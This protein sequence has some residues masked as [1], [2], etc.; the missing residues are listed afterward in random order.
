[1]TREIKIKFISKFPSSRVFDT[2]SFVLGGRHHLKLR[3][4]LFSFVGSKPLIQ[5]SVLNADYSFSF[6]R[7][8]YPKNTVTEKR[9][10]IKSELNRKKIDYKNYFP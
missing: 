4:V 10:R 8:H 6:P 7:T 3:G 1:M 9:Y 2:C 5:S